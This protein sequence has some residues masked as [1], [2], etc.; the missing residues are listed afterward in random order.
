MERFILCTY[1]LVNLP[2]HLW[3]FWK[4]KFIFTYCLIEKVFMNP[5]KWKPWLMSVIPDI[6]L[7]VSSQSNINTFWL[8][9]TSGSLLSQY[10]LT[11]SWQ[12]PRTKWRQRHP[13]SLSFKPSIFYLLKFH[14]FWLLGGKLAYGNWDGVTFRNA[15]WVINRTKFLCSSSFP[16]HMDFSVSA[17]MMTLWVW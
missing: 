8:L 15:K 13:P 12:V 6:L 4:A 17:A 7:C 16:W 14:Y 1:R 5:S 2:L 3:E 11:I 9:T 10:I